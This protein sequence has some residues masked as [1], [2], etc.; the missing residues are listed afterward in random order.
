M[1]TAL[2]PLWA[3]TG[4]RQY[5]RLFRWWFE[6][7]IHDVKTLLEEFRSH[8]VEM[9]NHIHG[10]NLKADAID[11]RVAS[12]DLQF[13]QLDAQFSEL[14][15]QFSQYTAAQWDAEAVTRRLAAIE[16]RSLADA[17]GSTDTGA[18]LGSR[19]S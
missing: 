9:L 11:A 2:K 19:D 10:L 16:D 17:D 18:A 13:S 12:L 6:A 15:G 3:K 7:I 8:R 14:H 1:K 4:G 5:Y